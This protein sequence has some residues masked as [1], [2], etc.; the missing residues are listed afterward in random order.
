MIVLDSIKQI[1]LCFCAS[2]ILSSCSTKKSKS[3]IEVIFSRDTL[4]IGYT[5]W[6]SQTAPFNGNCEDSHSL[7]FTGTIKDIAAVNDTSGPLYESQEGIIEIERLYKIK[8]IGANIYA[9]QKFIRTDCFFESNLKEGDT[10][11]VFCYDYE[12]AYTIPGKECI[13]KIKGFDDALIKSVRKYIDANDDLT[14]LRK[15][16]EV[17]D[18]VGLGTAVENGLVACKEDAK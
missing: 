2:F 14:A 17:W 11:L 9:E 5:Y 3:E 12:D 1:V 4:A 16:T 6:W 13:V 7:V 18:A 10:V 8:D 15:D